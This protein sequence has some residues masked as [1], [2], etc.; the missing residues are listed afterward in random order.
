MKIR[1]TGKSFKLKAKVKHQILK[2]FN[3]YDA[4]F[5]KQR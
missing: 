3:Q 5:T 4:K 2:L 1:K